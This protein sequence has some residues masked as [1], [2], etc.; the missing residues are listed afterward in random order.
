MKSG[1][2][3]KA[4]R[5]LAGAAIFLGG[6]VSLALAVLA[7]IT[8]ESSPFWV[9]LL[10]I[11]FFAVQGVFSNSSSVSL[12]IAGML[13]ALGMIVLLF[14]DLLRIQGLYN[15]LEGTGLHYFFIAVCTF[16]WLGHSRKI[17]KR[18]N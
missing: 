14:G 17:S 7:L 8:E 11:A 15:S 6:A 2:A 5:F 10:F 4:L 3:D 9:M 13:L 18:G 16:I 1:P 12:P